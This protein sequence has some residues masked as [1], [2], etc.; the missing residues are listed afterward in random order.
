MERVALALLLGS[1][2]AG[3]HAEAQTGT[4]GSAAFEEAR[5]H[6]ELGLQLME[7]ENWDGALV[8]FQRSIEVHPTRSSLFNAGMCLKALYRYVEAVRTFERW[9]SDFGTAASEDER[10]RVAAAIEGVQGFIGQVSV[11][12][13]VAGAAVTLDGEAVGTSPLSGPVPVGVGHHVAEARFEGREPTREEV[14]VGARE[15]VTVA[16]QI[17]PAAESGPAP[18]PEAPVAEE[19]EGGTS[20][21]WFWTAAATAAALGIGGAVT[22]GLALGK[23][24]AFDDAASRCQAG[25]PQACED[26]RSIGSDGDALE[27]ATNVLLPVA[28][29]L[30][31][32]AIVLALFTDFGDETADDAGVEIIAG[33]SPTGVT[34]DVV[35]PF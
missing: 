27:L 16:L 30:A 24:D 19:E 5:Q 31:V 21:A 14:A 32:T 25:D 11:S 7:N 18:V 33:P 10:L 26:G 3:S 17:A 15:R 4:E 22:G 29:A 1:S 20:P 9:Q 2:L 8:E 23:Q 6:F 34:L 12:V 13:N 35:V 28:G